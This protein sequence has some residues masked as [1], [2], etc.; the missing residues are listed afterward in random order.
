MKFADLFIFLLR[1]FRNWLAFLNE[2]THSLTHSLTV[3]TEGCL[4]LEVEIGR[5]IGDGSGRKTGKHLCGSPELF[6]WVRCRVV[7]EERL[8]P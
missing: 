1:P 4:T 7:R 5:E 6:E 2:D 3:D 8:S